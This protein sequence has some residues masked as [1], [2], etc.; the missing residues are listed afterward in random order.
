M[1]QKKVTFNNN[2]IIHHYDIAIEQDLQ[3][4]IINDTKLNKCYLK[5]SIFLL[6]IKKI[7]FNN[8][9]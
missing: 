1:F 2:I 5:F 3:T 4:K 7:F 8:F 6:K 9:K